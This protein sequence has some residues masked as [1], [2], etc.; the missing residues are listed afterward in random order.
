MAVES[1]DQVRCDVHTNWM[2]GKSG[3]CGRRDF[4]VEQGCSD[5]GETILF[6]RK[7]EFLRE[8]RLLKRVS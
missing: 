1:T 5:C 2:V 3:K 4:C 6:S 7:M 8:A